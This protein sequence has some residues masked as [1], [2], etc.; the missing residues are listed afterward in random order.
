MAVPASKRETPQLQYVT[1]ARRLAREVFRVADRYPSKQWAKM[2]RSMCDDAS[3]A[4]RNALMV[5]A[6]FL[7]SEGDLAR[8]REL[9]EGALG[10][11]AHLEVML[12]L[13]IRDFA[14]L[15]AKSEANA[16]AEAA[17]DPSG[18]PPRIR[19]RGPTEKELMAI[20]GLVTDERN[21]LHGLAKKAPELLRGHL[22]RAGSPA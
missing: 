22:A 21:L 8:E 19:R 16:A 4:L 2:G 18:K 6:I 11:L 10:Y 17:A 12:D 1:T 15:N 7:R 3:M 13:S 20:A 9:I 14:R 5:D